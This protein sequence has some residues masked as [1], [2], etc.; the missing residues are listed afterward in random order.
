VGFG[1]G[2]G[3][4]HVGGGKVME[5]KS[6]RHSGR[7][8]SRQTVCKGMRIRRWQPGQR[9]KVKGAITRCADTIPLAFA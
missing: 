1:G 4:G 8:Y 3:W 5:E 9:K 2:V 6:E 7:D